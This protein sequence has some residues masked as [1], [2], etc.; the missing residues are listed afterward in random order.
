[1]L[2]S[3]ADAF[4]CVCGNHGCFECHASAAGLVR[5]WRAKGGDAAAISLDCAKDD[6]ERMRAGEPTATAAWTAYRADLAAGLA[7]LVTFY[8]PSL[9]VLGGGLSK[10]PELYDGLQAAVDGATL[11]ATRGKVAIAQSALSSDCAAMGAAWLVFSE[12]DEEAVASPPAAAA[13]RARAAAA[14]AV[15]S[16]ASV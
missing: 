1:M 9:I 12:V 5:H 2:R 6:V 11:P 8:N 7:N 3:G 16:C 13:A 10:T 15:R 4:A 14:A